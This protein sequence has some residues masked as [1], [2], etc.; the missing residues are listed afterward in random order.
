MLKHWSQNLSA[1]TDDNYEKKREREEKF[2]IERDT[3]L[4]DRGTEKFS[5][6]VGSQAVP[7][8]PAGGGK[9]EG[10]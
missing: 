5:G 9:F 3:T 8:C 7:A 2:G 6:F 4:K 10:V 1:G